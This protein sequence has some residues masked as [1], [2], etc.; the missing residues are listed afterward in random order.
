LKP[1]IAITM[2]EPA[3]VGPEVV[4]RAL[5]EPAVWQVCDPVVLGHTELLTR[6]ASAQGLAVGFVDAEKPVRPEGP[7]VVPVLDGQRFDA[8]TVTPGK[9]VP[10]TGPVVIGWIERAVRLAREGKVQAMATGPI[11]KAVLHQAGFPFPG[12]TEFL[13]S[14]CGVDR[15]VM[16]LATSRLRVVLATIHLR[17]EEVP[18]ALARTD[19]LAL[20][21]VIHASLRLDFGL[22]APRIAVAALNPHGGEGGLFGDEEARLIHPAVEAARA[23]GIDA[24]GPFP[25][26]TLFFHARGGA[27]DAVLCMYHDQGLIPL[28]MD[29][30]LEAVNVTLGLPIVRASVDHGTAYDLVGTGR[31]DAGSLVQA[32]R[33]A[34][35]IAANRA[36]SLGETAKNP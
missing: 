26:D 27:H 1:L 22:A 30:F 28:K 19:L 12:H 15:P 20:L 17:L 33:T 2:G 21:R 8:S 16:M 11:D 6:A 4:A 31:A 24:R 5:V 32:L 9:P 25:A 34:A 10:E 35:A 18:A 14:L 29:G 7:S 3:G 13:G 36:K 23:E